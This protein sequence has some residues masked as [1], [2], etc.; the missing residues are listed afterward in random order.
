[1]KPFTLLLLSFSFGVF[2]SY[3]QTVIHGSI[4]SITG[5]SLPI[6]TLDVSSTGPAD[7]FNVP[8]KQI[9]ES[10][11]KYRID[12][13]SP[14]IYE[15]TVRGVFHRSVSIPVMIYDQD[16]IELTIHLVP[17]EYNSGRH[18]D[19]RTFL[20]WARA[21]GNFNGYDFFTG[22][23]FRA[24]KDGSISAF[25]KTDKD[26]IR[27]QVK[28]LSNG[29]DILPGADDYAVRGQSFEAILYNT[30]GT[31]S[32]ELR[33]HP[34]EPLPYVYEKPDGLQHWQE[35]LSAFLHFAR[36][37]DKFWVEPLQLTKS[38]IMNFRTLSDSEA[39]DISTKALNE[40]LYK[41]Y[42]WRSTTKF[43]ADRESIIKALQQQD[44]HP[45]QRSALLISYIGLIQQQ[46][47]RS[48][49]L[50]K[51]G[52]DLKPLNVDDSVLQEAIESVDPRNPVWTL[53]SYAAL[54][55]LKQSDYSDKAV[56]YA[57]LMI[58][59]HADDMVVRN[60]VLN[61]IERYANR[62]R[63]AQEMPYYSWIVDRYGE[64]NLARRAITTF[65]Q[66]TN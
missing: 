62:Y 51:I 28:G 18:F 48:E 33:Y 30:P 59:H 27:Y 4:L 32:I 10:D 43:A 61:L 60:L 31:D 11:G 55:L 47:K 17:V 2:T 22:E 20:K 6:A 53:N 3:A 66:S 65:R 52:R 1:M 14:G 7:I 57:E 49:Y 19:K 39:S 38:N 12:F 58:K 8:G 25:I 63:N 46:L 23:S 44:L 21:Y 45:H 35:P 37:T 41:S 54:T 56:D 34:D 50:E 26:T 13:S 42:D 29:S 24:N 40:Y 5:E 64:N 15:L 9:A 16:Q 36:S